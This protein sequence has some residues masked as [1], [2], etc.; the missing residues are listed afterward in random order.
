MQN[1]F[2][3]FTPSDFMPIERVVA[4]PLARQSNDVLVIIPT[5]ELPTVSILHKQQLKKMKTS[6]LAFINKPFR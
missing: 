1:E 3:I 5:V 6:R 4:G 2:H